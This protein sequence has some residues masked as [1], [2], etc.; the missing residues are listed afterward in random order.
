ML[1]IVMTKEPKVQ[2]TAVKEMREELAKLA[3]EVE[4]LRIKREP[5]KRKRLDEMMELDPEEWD[6]DQMYESFGIY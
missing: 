1:N 2:S 5:E 6:L 4:K 3:V